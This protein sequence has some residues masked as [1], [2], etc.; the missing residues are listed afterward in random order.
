MSRYDGNMSASLAKSVPKEV[1]RFRIVL[2]DDHRDVL[3]EIRSLLEEEFDTDAVTDGLALIDAARTYKPDVV[4]S[5][6]QMPG[7]SGIEACDKILQK[8]YSNA[9]IILTMYNEL[10]LV[11]TALRAG[12]QG[13]VLKVDAGEEL[14]AAVR[15]V[16]AGSTYLSRGVERRPSDAR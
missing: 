15:S 6:I 4:I 8:G 11:A 7:M 5:D 9:A 13:Y 14:I 16:L 1:R 2:A 12:I 3:R 10:P